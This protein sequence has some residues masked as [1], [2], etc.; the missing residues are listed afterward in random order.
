MSALFAVLLAVLVV[1]L[2]E[3]TH[4]RAGILDTA[5]GRVALPE[6]DQV[7]AELAAV[8]VDAGCVSLAPRA[9]STAADS[10]T[11]PRIAA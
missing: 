4:R 6:A 11:T 10:S 9:A 1:A 3:R 7:R 2:L 5:P 8:S